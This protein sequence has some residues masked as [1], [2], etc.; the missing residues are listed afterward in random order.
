MSISTPAGGTV[1]ANIAALHNRA[2]AAHI[3]PV[4]LHVEEAAL[5]I[6]GYV[7]NGAYDGKNRYDWRLRVHCTRMTMRAAHL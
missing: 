4:S 1:L 5:Q 7:T 2:I 6:N 3:L